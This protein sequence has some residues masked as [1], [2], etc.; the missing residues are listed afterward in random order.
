MNG[1]KNKRGNDFYKYHRAIWWV[2]SGTGMIAIAFGY[3]D[4]LV[5]GFTFISMFIG[6]YAHYKVKTKVANKSLEPKTPTKKF[7]SV[8]IASVG[9][10]ITGFATVDN[11]RLATTV[12]TIQSETKGYT[13]IQRC[14]KSG[15][16]TVC[17]HEGKKDGVQL[18]HLNKGK[19][20]DVKDITDSVDRYMEEKA[21]QGDIGS[22]RMGK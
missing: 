7:V 21:T 13:T 15:D 2:V 12:A 18:Y 19:L 10:L 3:L 22:G 6:G 17:L 11:I 20:K 8:A 9:L 1:V 16:D 4:E 5:I 14:Q